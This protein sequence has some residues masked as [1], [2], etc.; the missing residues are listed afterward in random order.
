MMKLAIIHF[1]PLEKYPPI[2]N[3]LN[4]LSQK[5]IASIVFTTHP[6]E[7]FQLYANEL[8]KIV[9]FQS[10]NRVSFLRVLHYLRFYIGTIIHLIRYLPTHLI[11]FETLS[12]FPAIIYYYIT[13]CKP[14]LF[15]HYHE[16]ESPEEILKGMFLSRVFHRM[17]RKI[18]PKL[19]WLSQ[20]NQD[21]LDF[22]LMDNPEINRKIART[23]PNYPPKWWGNYRRKRCSN[24]D[25][26]KLVYV[27]ALS[28]KT[29]YIKEII[30]LIKIANGK[31]SCDFYSFSV[32]KQTQ[33]LFEQNKSH[34]INFRGA[35]SQSDFPLIISQYQIGLVLY[36]GHIP[37]YIYNAPN[38]LFE[39][40]AC[41]LDVW[42]PI[43]MKGIDPYRRENTYPKVLPIDFDNIRDFNWQLAVC[44]EGLKEEIKEF[45]FEDIYQEFTHELIRVINP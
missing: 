24:A 43:C 44:R 7:A 39:Y 8:H 15:V 34:N 21:R 37:N 17:E 5:G 1:Q 31:L 25:T 45:Y 35:I 12:S 11:W 40:L 13:T 27:G 20:T 6:P 29:L 38:K 41:G 36:K 14:K 22:F 3:L 9:R 42:Y 32:D 2:V 28:T 23:M 4:F 26:I 19:N 33:M 18:Y 30:E 10:I 16:Y